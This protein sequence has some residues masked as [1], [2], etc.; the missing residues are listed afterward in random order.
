MCQLLINLVGKFKKI[1][2]K[3]NRWM[4]EGARNM[5]RMQPIGRAGAWLYNVL[6]RSQI[7]GDIWH[8]IFIV[9]LL[10]TKL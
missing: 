5:E 4:T 6:E 2:K 8:R 10:S 7:Q 1:I 9:L 3:I